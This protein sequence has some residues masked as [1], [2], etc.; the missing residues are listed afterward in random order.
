MTATTRE[1][2]SVT[3]MF[4]TI[5]LKWGH[6]FIE[7]SWVEGTAQLEHCMSDAGQWQEASSTNWPLAAIA[8][9]ARA[10]FRIV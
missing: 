2:P 4:A 8:A 9:R 6:L 7:S 5:A 1:I 3:G 10:Q